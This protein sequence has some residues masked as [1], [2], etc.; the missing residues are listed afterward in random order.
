MYVDTSDLLSD[1]SIIPSRA[2]WVYEFDSQMHRT[3]YGRFSTRPQFAI[4]SVIISYLSKEEVDVSHIIQMINQDWRV[5]VAVAKEREH[6]R[7]NARFYA[8]MTLEMRLYQIATEG[9]IADTIFKYIKEQYMTMGEEQ[10][11]RTN[12]RITSPHTDPTIS[13]HKFVV[14]EFSAWCTNFRWEFSQDVFRD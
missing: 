14:I 8:K 4:K 7:T 5:I 10:L 6:K 9:N 13:K 2:H 12:T 11:L 1:K 3:L